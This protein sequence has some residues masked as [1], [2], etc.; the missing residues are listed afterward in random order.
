M[1]MQLT[2]AVKL[3]RPPFDVSYDDRLL[4][5]GSCFAEEVGRSLGEDK[6][7]VDVNPFGMLYN[8]LS[9]AASLRRL[10]HPEA[11]TADTLF[12]L[13]GLYH[14]FAHHGRFSAASK[15]EALEGMNERLLSSASFLAKASRLIITWGTAF[16]YRLKQD[17]TVVANCHKLPEGKFLRERL[18]VEHIVADWETLFHE[19]WAANPGLKVIFTVSPIRHLRDGLHDNNLSKATLLLSIDRLKERQP[20]RI[21]YF[22]AYEIV[23]DELR[24]YRYYADDMLHP[25]PLA[26]RY[27]GER[28][29]ACFF[30]AD[31]LACL[32]EWQQLK[33]ALLHRPL[34]P[35][36]ESHQAFLRNTL[37]KAM[38]LRLNHPSLDLSFEINHLTSQL[39]Q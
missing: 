33:P 22:P 4:L 13:D 14:S 5:V 25:S 18:S 15:E 31:T 21:A 27:V 11:F 19:L 39:Q 26:V 38:Q 2:T 20:E 6:F 7:R 3:S 8:P 36:A 30:S 24:D 9:V 32:A 34:R 35:G 37:S 29:A 1:A 23:L 10:L 12:C 17:G 28:F 16:V